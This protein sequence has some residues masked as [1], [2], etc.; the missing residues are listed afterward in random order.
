M[1]N[2]SASA[3]KNR[4][5]GS[6]SLQRV[7]WRIERIGQGIVVNWFPEDSPPIYEMPPPILMTV[8]NRDGIHVES[9]K[10]KHFYY[11]YK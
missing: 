8:L 5:S 7:R 1:P 10:K 4:F 11:H 3:F 9:L 6:A 2:E